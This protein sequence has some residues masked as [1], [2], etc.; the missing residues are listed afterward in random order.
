[1]DVETAMPMRHKYVIVDTRYCRYP[2]CTA[3]FNGVDWICAD[4]STVM[5]VQF[6]AYVQTP[7]KAHGDGRQ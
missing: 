5:N 6:W 3:F 4:D 1:M 2:F 7:A